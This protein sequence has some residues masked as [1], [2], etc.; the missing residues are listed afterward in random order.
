MPPAARKGDMHSCPA[1]SGGV[2]HNGGVIMGPGANSVL[3]NGVPAAV[4][5]DAMFCFGSIDKITTGS[6]TVFINGRPAARMGDHS[7]H[8]GTITNGAANVLIG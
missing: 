7:E 4:V 1:Q 2:P 5:G 6:A 3:I 8:G